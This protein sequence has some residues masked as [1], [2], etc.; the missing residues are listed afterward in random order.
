[1]F[2]FSAIS[3]PPHF[4]LLM[5]IKIYMLIQQ[6]KRKYNSEWW[7]FVYIFYCAFSYFPTGNSLERYSEQ[8]LKK[9]KEVQ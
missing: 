3:W 7:V 8:D 4:F 2:K 1:M 9:L 6:K 5:Y